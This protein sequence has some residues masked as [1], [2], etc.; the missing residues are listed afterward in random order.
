MTFV[1]A[2]PTPQHHKRCLG[3]NARCSFTELADAVVKLCLEVQETMTPL[4]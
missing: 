3:V 4:A 1:H 2:T